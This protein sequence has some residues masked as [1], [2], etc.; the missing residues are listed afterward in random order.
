MHTD[1]QRAGEDG[2]ELADA[3]HVGRR[4]ENSE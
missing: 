4:L 3:A 2:E 1:E